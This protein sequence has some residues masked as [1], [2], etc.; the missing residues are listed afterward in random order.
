M[1]TTSRGQARRWLDEW[2]RLLHGPVDTLLATLVSSSPKSRE[3]RQNTPFAG[4]LGEA[5]HAEVLAAWQSHDGRG[6]ILN[7]QQLALVLRAA[8]QVVD[9]PEIVVLGSQAIL[10][11]FREDE[12]PDEVVVSMEA[13]LAFRSDVD[14][15]KSDSVDGA[16][17]EGSP[18][19]EV[20]SYY[21]QASPS[22]RPC[23][24]PDGSNEPSSTNARMRYQVTRSALS[25]MIS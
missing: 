20:Y 3:L 1:R 10:G 22:A 16:I 5:E 12:L 18:F 4:V 21:A 25:L 23:W 14:G 11:R 9:D 13:D 24:R 19:H 17:G 2:E 8:S 15:S 7:G 6:S